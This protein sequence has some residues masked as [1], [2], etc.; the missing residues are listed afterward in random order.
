MI[1]ILS[2]NYLEAERFARSQ[3]WDDNEWF[4]PFSPEEL[5]TKRNFHVL[6]IGT[7]GQNVPPS[8]FEKIW[9]VAKHQGRL[10]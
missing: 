10:K 5:L 7:A 9:T 2:G 4:Y 3:E 6:V 1:C 8:Y